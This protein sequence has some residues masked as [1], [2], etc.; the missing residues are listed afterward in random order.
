LEE[1]STFKKTYEVDLND[2]SNKPVTFVNQNQGTNSD[3]DMHT[4]SDDEIVAPRP[5]RQTQFPNRLNDCAIVP[6]N[7]VNNEG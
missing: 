3:E 5:Q 6:D 1:K 4:S 7:E 2:D